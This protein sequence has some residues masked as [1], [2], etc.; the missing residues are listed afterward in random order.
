VL[1]GLVVL[2]LLGLG[3]LALRRRV[4]TRRGGTFDC[5]LRLREG[6]N[7]KGW[8]LG[9]GRYAGDELEWY[10]VFSYSTR[11]R[12]TFVRRNL[13]VVDRREPTGVEVFS[14]LSGAVV[15][16]CRD[17]DHRLELAMSSEALTGFLSW[18]ESAPPGIPRS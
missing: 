2:A 18:V 10:R 9:I 14:L 16:S 12:R 1:V 7:G 3:L 15:V 17:G 5:S 11:P 4:I 13:R 6:P 8:V